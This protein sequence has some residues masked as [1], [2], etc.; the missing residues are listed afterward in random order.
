[1]EN[2]VTPIMWATITHQPH[3]LKLLLAAGADVNAIDDQ[4]YTPLMWAA[5]Y[6]HSELARLL[7]EADA[8]QFLSSPPQ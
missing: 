4:G 8:T 1:M 6:G 3:I 5:R 7:L 2:S